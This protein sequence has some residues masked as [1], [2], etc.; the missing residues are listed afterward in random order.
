M[1]LFSVYGTFCFIENQNDTVSVYFLVALLFNRDI[2]PNIVSDQEFHYSSA[3]VHS[4]NN[5]GLL[6]DQSSQF[7]PLALDVGLGYLF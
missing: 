6:L 4:C 5:V 3:H 1:Y 2:P 7:Y